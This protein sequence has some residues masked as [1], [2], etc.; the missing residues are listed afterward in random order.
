MPTSGW[1][2]LGMTLGLSWS[3]RYDTTDSLLDMKLRGIEIIY[4]EDYFS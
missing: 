4:I 1:S 3:R 2:P